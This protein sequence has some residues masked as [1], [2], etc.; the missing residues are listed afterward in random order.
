M[1]TKSIAN[2]VI[3]GALALGLAAGA[4]QAKPAREDAARLETASAA[5]ASAGAAR[6]AQAK[7][8]CA[9]FHAPGSLLERKVCKTREEWI[10]L[11][12]EIRK[13]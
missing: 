11:G 10:E 4:A 12:A 3:A 1:Y 6:P 5:A 7:L 13:K 8:L 9:E 2:I